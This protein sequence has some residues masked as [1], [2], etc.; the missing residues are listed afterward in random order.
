M[1]QLAELQLLAKYNRLMNERL[2]EACSVLTEQ[3]LQENRGAFFN[4]VLGTLNHIL[5]GDII[6]LKR[7]A[8]HPANFK[9]LHRLNNYSDPATLDQIIFTDFNQLRNERA[10]LDNMFISFCD[11]LTE[12]VLP[13]SLAYNNMKGKPFRKPFGSLINHLFLHSIHHRG[14]ATTLLSQL[15]LDFGD[16]D[17]IE[18]IEDVD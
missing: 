13:T 4:S 5:V 17:I 1:T 15:N 6:W 11:E 7:F 3:Q 16:T 9:S 14:Q 8:N 2:F 10:L 12:N 18:I